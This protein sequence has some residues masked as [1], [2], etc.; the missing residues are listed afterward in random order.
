MEELKKKYI[1]DIVSILKLIIEDQLTKE[2][3]ADGACILLSI[4]DDSSFVDIDDQNY[5]EENDG[6]SKIMSYLNSSF[7]INLNSSI[8]PVW[9]LN[10]KFDDVET[11]L[12]T[13]L[14]DITDILVSILKQYSKDVETLICRN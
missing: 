7:I 9:R 6:H 12:D 10:Q 11:E 3:Y 4:A 1:T 8:L 5:D 14:A 13:K 2:D